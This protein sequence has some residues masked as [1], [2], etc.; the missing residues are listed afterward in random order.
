MIVDQ[1]LVRFSL[2]SMRA[3]CPA[4]IIPLDLILLTIFVVK[5]KFRSPALRNNV[6]TSFLRAHTFFLSTVSSPLL[7]SCL[8]SSHR[9][10]RRRLHESYVNRQNVKPMSTSSSS[11]QLYV[12]VIALKV[13]QTVNRWQWVSG[14]HCYVMKTERYGVTEMG[15]FTG[16]WLQE[17]G[18]P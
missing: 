18:N 14:T 9:N 10:H 11:V 5:Y 17:A 15:K 3:T 4:H 2:P 16:W 7:L 6:T 12:N 8:L 1:N 13:L